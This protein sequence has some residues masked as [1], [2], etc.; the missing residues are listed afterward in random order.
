MKLSKYNELEFT[1]QLQYSR[2]PGKHAHPY[3]EPVSTRIYFL[4]IFVLPRGR[5]DFPMTKTDRLVFGGIFSV[6]I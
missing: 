2:N 5:S 4:Q 3:L 1:A 6:R